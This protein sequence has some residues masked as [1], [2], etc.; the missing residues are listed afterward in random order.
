MQVVDDF[1]SSGEE[2]DEEERKSRGSSMR[3]QKIDAY[4]SSTRSHRSGIKKT[5]MVDD[6]SSMG[7]SA[8]SSQ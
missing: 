1:E 6:F 4:S 8:M 3:A 5:Q 7:G 2:G